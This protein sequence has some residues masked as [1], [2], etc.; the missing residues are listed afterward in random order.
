MSITDQAKQKLSRYIDRLDIIVPGDKIL[1]ACSGGADSI[2]LLYL[3]TL[4]RY[5]YKLSLLAIHI[6]HQSRPGANEAELELV[7][8]H[9]REM[10]VPLVVRKIAPQPGA[11]FESRARE[12]RFHEFEQILKLYRFNK[13]ALGH[14]KNDQA[15][16]VLM[17]LL[18]GAGING[19]AGIK[20]VNNE[21]IHPLLT[22]AKGELLDLLREANLAWAEDISNQDN[23]YRRNYLRNDLIPR[24]QSEIHPEVIEKICQQAEISR[25]AEAYLRL[26]AQKHLKKLLIDQSQTELRL[27]LDGLKKLNRM[28]QYYVLKLAY[29]AVSNIEQDFFWHNLAEIQ[30]LYDAEGSKYI[31]CQN[32]ITVQ[33][34]YEQLIFS[35]EE[36]ARNVP[37]EPMLLEEDRARAVYLDYRF[38]FK[39]IKVLPGGRDHDKATIY[40]DQDKIVGALTIRT[41]QAGDRFMPSGMSH[42][43]KLK[44]FFIDEKIPKYERDKIAII[45][46]SEK[47][48]WIAGLRQDQRSMPD[49]SSVRYLQI[50]VE[51]VNEKP[52][53]AAS[54]SKKQGE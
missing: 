11:G 32:G 45:C 15:E 8:D 21:I 22:F 14:H 3:L 38:T 27:S 6:N 13:I 37:S 54:R 24:L 19:M 48:I 47:I 30:A 29:T 16:T 49:E 26:I 44:D 46:D 2:A 42:L 41:R 25:E 17:N 36:R 51:A 52:K 20:P 40:I 35:N 50:A 4:I 9:C 31:R 53:R 23:K 1:I 12:M 33:K 7:K 39:N 34:Q 28:E 18:R 43:K 10:N 5:D